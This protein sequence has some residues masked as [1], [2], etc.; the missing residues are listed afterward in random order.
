MLNDRVQHSLACL[1]VPQVETFQ[2]P[3]VSSHNAFPRIS[4]RNS[5]SPLQLLFCL[6]ISVAAHSL[7]FSSLYS[8]IS[9]V[10]FPHHTFN[11]AFPNLFDDLHESLFENFG[12]I[13]EAFS[14]HFFKK[15]FCFLFYDFD[16]TVLTYPWV[17]RADHTTCNAELGGAAS[18]GKNGT[19]RVDE[20][21]L[22]SLFRSKVSLRPSG[23]EGVFED[24]DLPVEKLTCYSA[25]G[26]HVLGIVLVAQE[27]A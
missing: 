14:K 11:T 25:F 12:G 15:S 5:D 22:D 7:Y 10:I 6:N 23:A 4:P 9:G 19:C 8:I 21:F 16:W 27:R 26:L 1:D 2:V 13:E 18:G 20:R 17:E 24:E 3:A